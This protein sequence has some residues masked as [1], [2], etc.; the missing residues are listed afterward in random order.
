MTHLRQAMLDEL[1]RRNYAPGTIRHYVRHVAQFA[2]FF[3]RSPHR[4]NPTHL[5]TYQAYLLRDRKLTPR[6][7]MLHA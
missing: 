3:K 7:A 4:L 2:R 1:Q 6:T 5:R